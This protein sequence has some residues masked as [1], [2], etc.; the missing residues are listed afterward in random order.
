MIEK[1]ILNAK[2]YQLVEELV[3]WETKVKDII[4]IINSSKAELYAKQCYKKNGVR[5]PNGVPGSASTKSLRLDLRM[6]YSALAVEYVN[7][8]DN[9]IHRIE[10]MLTVFRMYWNLNFNVPKKNKI[11]ASV[12]IST[13]R[14]INCGI[15][16][17]VTCYKC[18]GKFLL[19]SNVIQLKSDRCIWCNHLIPKHIF[20]TVIN[21]Q[22]SMKNY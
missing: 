2:D 13:T 10:A 21:T 7:A 5:P 6:Q 22:F 20:K 15:E 11:K 9:E 12:W 3:E 16:E 18:S 8:L 19:D 14:N 17:L 1:R 4:W